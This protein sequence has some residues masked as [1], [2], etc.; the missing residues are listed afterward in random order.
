MLEVFNAA[1]S[2]K[3]I[4]ALAILSFLQPDSLIIIEKKLKNRFQ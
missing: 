3:T 2:T 4:G 1:K